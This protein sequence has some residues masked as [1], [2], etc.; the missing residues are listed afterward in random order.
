MNFKKLGIAFAG[1]GGKGAYQIGVWNALRELGLDRH[2]AAIAGTSVG[3]LNGAMMAQGRYE[4][5]E[6][7]WRKV[8]AHNLLALEGMAGLAQWVAQRTPPGHVLSRLTA[9]AASKGLFKQ[10]GLRAMID[11]GVDAPALARSAVPLTVTW[12]HG[13]GN[14]A[15]YR[16]LRDPATVADGLLATAAL[17][18]IFDQVSI[19]GELYSDGGF[20]WGIPGRQ[21]DNTPVRPLHE[22][23][24]DTVIVVCLSQDDLTVA[25]HQFPGMRLIPIVPRR[26]PGNIMATVDFSD[27]GAARRIEQG[28]TDAKEVLRHLAMY[29]ET[30]DGYRVLWDEVR[31][32]AL[33]ES[34]TAAALAAADRKHAAVVAQGA[35]FDRIVAG[36]DFTRALAPAAGDMPGPAG[37]LELESAA[38]LAELDRERIHTDVARFLDAH[39]Q[40]ARGVEAVV[41]DALAALS[42]VHGRADGMRAQGLLARLL[43][44][45]TGRNAA[46]AADNA[47]AL[48][49]GQYA[50]L[51]LIDAVRKQGAL[52]LEFS[53]TLQNRLQAGL[54]EMARLGQRQGDDM[55][56]VYR[57]LAGVYGKLRTGLMRHGEEIAALQ[58]QSRLHHWLLHP[59]RARHGG[60]QLASLAPTLRLV[61]VANEFFALTGGAWTADELVSAKE[62]CHL[63]GLADTSIQ[64]GSFVAD[65]LGDG[66]SAPA[67]SHALAALPLAAP[68][69]GVAGWLLALRAG[70]LAGDTWPALACWNYA[71]QAELPAWDLLVELLYHMRA[72]GLAPL[73]HDSALSG[74]K[75]RWIE[76]LAALDAM[77]AEG[78]LPAGF[79]AETAP[80]RAAI[81]AF[82][83]KVPLVG[84]F[85]VGK[86]ALV[87]CWLDQELQEVD[88]AA[89]TSVPVEFHYAAPG[90]EKLVVRWAPDGPELAAT[91]EEFDDPAMSEQRVLAF[92]RGRR[93][94]HIERHCELPA[95]ARH[96]DLVVV[97][98]PGLGSNRLD[99]DTALAHYLGDSVTFI[100]CAN[101][102]QLGIDELA[103]IR[104]QRQ[105][106][107]EFSLL[108]CKE[109]LNNPGE[110][111][112]LHQGLA[113]QAG[114]APGQMVRGCSAR[115]RNLAGFDD[116]LA[117][118]ERR[119]TALFAA[120]HR[121][122]VAG[123]AQRAR[124]LLEQ[125]LD[126]AGDAPLHERRERIEAAMAAL[127]AACEREERQL[128]A[129]CAD[130]LA[131]SVVADVGAFLRAR[132]SD[133]LRRA[134]ERQEIGAAL[135]AD[136]QN[137]YELAVGRHLGASLQ[138]AAAR[139]EQQVDIGPGGKIDLGTASAPGGAFAH[140]G[141]DKFKGAAFD[142][143][144]GSA[145]LA[146]GVI[147]AVGVLAAGAAF[148]YLRGSNE[149]GKLGELIDAEI[150]RL[151][152][153]VER[154]APGLLEVQVRVAIAGMRRQIAARL[155]TDRGQLERIDSLL[156]D[157]AARRADIKR[158]TDAALEQLRRLVDDDAPVLE[159]ND[160]A[161]N[162]RTLA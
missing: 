4:L 127:E 61:T 105:L 96:P 113:A 7:M 81:E 78:L 143:A 18:M 146:L 131:R 24:C 83:L 107:Q 121:D 135:A 40:D 161:I 94:L 114:L 111:A 112:S 151:C 22:A 150:A 70:D 91:F 72:A 149:R 36:D 97:D 20:Y 25:P 117:Q 95:L 134:E 123:L 32:S 69:P 124:R 92:G 54:Q 110:R 153:Q 55:V 65:L 101:R 47:I 80:V 126:G 128:L 129:A 64:M 132:R 82:R 35:D 46:L 154:Q 2:I 62:M 3:A 140:V 84:R 56:R 89:C 14:R 75:A 155:E 43:G 16:T 39:R 103:F 41:L 76:Q 106:G 145:V 87:N 26:S 33:R 6:Q 29:L 52:S 136:L 45:L 130:G 86:S 31:R 139:L 1:G 57:S 102:D 157:H 11:K 37:A 51:R 13:A 21:L 109:D 116:V 108:V 160:S 50:A 48:A 27:Q 148:R 44:T 17:P 138:Q 122:A 79:G 30:S 38:L 120:R 115:E 19:D 74:L 49:E 93:A 142:A 156:R 147:P 99:H 133:Y 98:T 158:R 73:R 159:A 118:V 100:L 141:A 63:V 42:P 10:D 104:R 5:A 162:G 88:L 90:Q 60:R 53:C 15:V 68:A 59:H 119:K 144:L 152:A 28:Y 125:A 66:E 77:V 71:A 23:G 9:S 67:L 34:D 85:S 8:E 137:G 12:H 58:R